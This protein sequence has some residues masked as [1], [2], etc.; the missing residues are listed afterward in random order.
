[1]DVSG[2]TQITGIFGYPIEH[3]LSPAM[4]NTA[5]KS[6]GL[7]YCYVPFKVLPVNLPDAVMAIRSLN[8]H[9]VN[10]TVPHKEKVIPLLDK[11]NEEASFIGAVNTIVN[12][13]GILTGYNTDGRGFMSSLTEEGVSVDGKDIVILGTGGACRAVSYYLSERSSKLSLFDIDR[14]KAENLVTDLQ[15]IRDS[16]SLLDKIED[17]GKPDIIINATPLGLKPDDP[18]PLDPD[19]ITPEM[20]VCDLVYKKTGLLE[21]A[22]RKGAKNIDG[23]GMLLWQGVL[24]FELWTG[25]KPPVDV[26]RSVL[27]SGIK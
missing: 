19:V 5:F 1:M 16:V 20:I 24:A 4:H 17:I 25:V 15:K 13:D 18:L 12:T 6:L 9:G 3:T 22:D 23:S 26:M 14:N 2:K 10:I 8:L 21:E 7:D 27:L 11:V